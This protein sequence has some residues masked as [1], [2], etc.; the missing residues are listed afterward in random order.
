MPATCVQNVT[1]SLSDIDQP[2]PLTCDCPP[3]SVHCRS[4]MTFNFIA[5]SVFTI[6]LTSAW[7]CTAEQNCAEYPLNQKPSD[8]G[9]RT[10][11]D[12]QYVPAAPLVPGP[13][14]A[15]CAAS[16]KLSPVHENSRPSRPTP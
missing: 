1:L 10:V 15:R 14:K 4:M 7:Y 9:K 6:C 8:S 13:M 2:A 3:A 12:H 16:M 11:F 5:V